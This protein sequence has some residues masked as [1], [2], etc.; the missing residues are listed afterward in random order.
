MRDP[1]ISQIGAD[2]FCAFICGN[3]R[4]LRMSI[5]RNE[6][7]TGGHGS[8]TLRAMIRLIAFLLFI[9]GCSAHAGVALGIDVLESQGF[10]P[11]AGK[12]IGLVTNQ[13]GVD[14]SGTKTRVIL[15]KAK[16]VKLV[17]LYSP[18]HGI[19]G[20]V[21]ASKYIPSRTDSLTGLPVFSLYGPTRKPTRDMLAGIDV[22]VYDM[23]DIGVRSYTYISTMA[24][25][26][27]ACGEQRIPFV[28]LDRPNPL[29]GLRIE[30][31]G[32][33]EKWK[34]FVG[35]LPVPYLHG[36]TT[37]E[38]AKMA[39]AYGWTGTRCQLGVVQ[40]QGWSR[41]MTWNRTGL[42]WVQT[43]PNIPR[44]NSVPYYAATSIFGSLEGGGLDVGIGTDEPFQ[45]AG[46]NGMDPSAFVRELR[47]TGLHGVSLEP[48]VR[49]EF[50]GARLSLNADSEVNLAAVNIQLLCAAQRQNRGSIFA[51][52]NDPDGIFWKIYGSAGIRSQ[53]EKGVSAAAIAASWEPGV[54]RFRSAR[55]PYLLY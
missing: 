53:I 51:R 15:R 55:Q 17:A 3:L 29:G 30:G 28:V 52:Y 26:M 6:V 38:L 12:R 2:F 34:S 14:S 24:K 44:A 47:A 13:T 48:Y 32:V 18:E 35:Q 40:M 25:C 1:Q 5:P 33:E 9:V 42:R 27:E 7:G 37:G 41:D 31:P 8:V 21:E 45:L 36:M 39:N 11:F 19:D 22:L 23:Q 50:G 20:T 49:K 4:N 10:A 46:K 43:S 54:A 16:N